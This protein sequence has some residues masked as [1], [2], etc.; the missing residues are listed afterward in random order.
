MSNR[1][2]VMAKSKITLFQK[3]LDA[4][5]HSSTKKTGGLKYSNAFKLFI[6]LVTLLTCAFFFYFHLQIQ[7]DVISAVK[8]NTGNIWSGQN[9][10]AE[11][12]FPVFKD[13][14]HLN[15]EMD[16]ASKAAL[17]VYDFNSD[18]ENMALLQ[19]EQII[20][21]FRLS[22][23]HPNSYIDTWFKNAELDPFYSI[24]SARRT[25]AIDKIE[26]KIREFLK[27]SYHQG[28]INT[29][30]DFVVHEEIASRF[31]QTKEKI[32]SRFAVLDSSDM[33]VKS[34]LF[35]VNKLV[36]KSIPVATKIISL[37]Y[38]PNLIYSQ[39]LTEKAAKNAEKSIAKT[40]G[41]VHKDELIISKGEKVTPDLLKK[42]RSYERSRMMRS[43]TDY[44]VWMMVGSFGHAA[45][46]YTILILYLFLIRK[47]IFQDNYQIIILS[48]VLSLVSA[49]SWLS[50]EI[51]SALPLQFF[52]LIPGMAMLVAIVFDSRTAFYVTVTMSLMIAGIRGNDYATGTT[53]M[54]AGTLAAYTVRDIQSRT[55]IFQ[56]IFFIFIGLGIPITAFGLESSADK[57]QILYN[58]AIALI[59]SAVSPLITFGFLFVLEKFTN[60]TTDLKLQEYTNLNHPL[61]V[62]MNE[63]APGTYQHTLSLAVLAEKC[64][65]AIG[66][67]DLLAKVGSYFHDIGKIAKAEYFVE[68]QI[69]IDNKHDSLTPKKSVEIIRKHVSD[70]V[71]LAE[72]YKLPK[73]IV[74]FIPMHHGTSLIK[75]F[76]ANALEN[77]GEDEEVRE[78]DYRYPGP[79]PKTKET[80]IVMIC[81]S[82]EAVSRLSSKNKEKLEKA[83]DGIIQD[84]LLYGQ[85]DDCN[86]T[87]K[88]LQKI[89]E[90]C[91]KHLVGVSHPRVEYK[92]IPEKKN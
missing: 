79:K 5:K 12:S 62:K 13:E 9:L 72:D 6:F 3:L 82:A 57:V 26:N 59:N 7:T 69:G 25:S 41:I 74:D 83:I 91:I 43:D 50:I 84:K 17:Q 23:D 44:S 66:A 14:V 64:A 92:N 48:I 24:D 31:S 52:V 68:N 37:I 55:Q 8:I 29:P 34:Q 56:S 81:D 27:E 75:Y 42:I 16:S 65:V 18:A 15:K 63:I 21:N 11:Y 89:K 19:L 28:M 80:A 61:L 2:I 88:D 71:K 58:L 73:R 47:K 32:Y 67:N 1:K 45:L 10:R 40:S 20:K 77:A 90:T 39:E 78:E 46:I 60:V 51:E 76:Y 38:Q 4:R 36:Q 35:F 53:M 54:F 86:L 30:K 49:T 33:M 22:T 70:G 85:F 87:F